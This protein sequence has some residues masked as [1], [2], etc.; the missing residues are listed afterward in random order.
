MS[1]S[2]K[3]YLA[4]CMGAPFGALGLSLLP[5]VMAGVLVP[6]TLGDG[7][8]GMIFFETLPAGAVGGSFLLLFVLNKKEPRVTDDHFKAVVL[9][10]LL[11][12]FPLA[13]VLFFPLM[14]VIVEVEKISKILA[15]HAQPALFIELFLI[16]LLVLILG[17]RF[18]QKLEHKLS[19]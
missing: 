6:A 8:F 17:I 7:Q 13:I 16:I 1:S 5:Y 3:M 4:L 19:S 11:G 12:C 14:F 2:V 9:W 15:Q 10:T 18:I